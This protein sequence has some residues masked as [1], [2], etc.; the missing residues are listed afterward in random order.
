MKKTKPDEEHLP[1][2]SFSSMNG[3]E[4]YESYD[5]FTGRTKRS[6]EIDGRT[7]KIEELRRLKSWLTKQIQTLASK[8]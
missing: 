3:I 8:T 6:I 2:F 1:T 7:M 5:M 4:F